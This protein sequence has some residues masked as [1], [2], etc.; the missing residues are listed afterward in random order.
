MREDYRGRY[1]HEC[2]NADGNT[3]VRCM[4]AEEYRGDEST[5]PTDECKSACDQ[6]QGCIGVGTHYYCDRIYFN[7]YDEGLA[8]A[9]AGMCTSWEYTEYEGPIACDDRNNGECGAP[10][11]TNGCWVKIGNINE[12][13][14]KLSFAEFK[15]LFEHLWQLR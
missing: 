5:E 7:K 8:N 12:L 4:L 13:K 6:V 11:N 1:N 9:P 15:V 10:I 14:S 2:Q 3:V